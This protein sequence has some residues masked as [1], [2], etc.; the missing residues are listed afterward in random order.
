MEPVGFEALSAVPMTLLD[1]GDFLHPEIMSAKFVSGFNLEI[2]H[3]RYT[4]LREQQERQL[5]REEQELTTSSESS[6]EYEDVWCE[7]THV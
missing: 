6:S 5:M 3:Q 4:F 7:F 1:L 2:V